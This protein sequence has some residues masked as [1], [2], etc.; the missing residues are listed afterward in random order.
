[1]RRIALFLIAC[2]AS[3]GGFAQVYKCRSG[4]TVAYLDRPC[5][6]G[7]S[8]EVSVPTAEHSE[9]AQARAAALR[10]REALLQL[11]K[12]RLASELR[13]QREAA[14]D[15]KA[16]HAQRRKCERLRLR[17]KWLEEDLAHSNGAAVDGVRLKAR[18]H[19][20]ALAVECP[21]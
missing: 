16:A 9:I 10:D 4:G 1:M 13:S 20:E 14:R 17:Q 8:I 6:D 15:Q 18:R 21:A 3:Q 11:E 12:V 7:V 2:A 19:A 5:P